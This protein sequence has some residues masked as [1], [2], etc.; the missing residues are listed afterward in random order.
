MDEG[1][2]I[3][4]FKITYKSQ[5]ELIRDLEGVLSAQIEDW[6][7]LT[8]PHWQPQFEVPQ[9]WDGW[10]SKFDEFVRR[11]TRDRSIVHPTHGVCRQLTT[12]HVVDGKTVPFIFGSK[13]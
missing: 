4:K 3:L 7:N 9:S 6:E 2:S 13:E 12:F 11:G 5:D 10:D 1:A 8:V